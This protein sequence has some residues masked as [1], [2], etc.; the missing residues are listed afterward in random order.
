M[1]R[2]TFSADDLGSFPDS[3]GS[4]ADGWYVAL[5]EAV[6]ALVPHHS[7]DVVV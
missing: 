2:L 1:L 3:I 4:A 6:G 7:V 5:K